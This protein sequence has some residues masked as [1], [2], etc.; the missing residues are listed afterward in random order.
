M[1]PASGPAAEV[2]R[3]GPKKLEAEVGMS[4]GCGLAA[5]AIPGDSPGGPKEEMGL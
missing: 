2:A 5:G 1:G 3:N 4:L